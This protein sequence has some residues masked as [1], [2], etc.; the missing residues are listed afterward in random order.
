M[1][2]PQQND[3]VDVEDFPLEAGMEAV[4]ID[5]LLN[6]GELASSSLYKGEATISFFY[7]VGLSCK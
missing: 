5:V 6:F 7:S 3:S 1:D 2:E 4:V